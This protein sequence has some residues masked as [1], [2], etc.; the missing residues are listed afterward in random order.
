MSTWWQY[1]IKN[2]LSNESI[3]WISVVYYKQTE[4]K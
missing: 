4:N 1:E 2:D 3:F